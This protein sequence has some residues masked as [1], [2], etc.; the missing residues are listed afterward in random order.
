MP[1]ASAD[2]RS[3]SRRARTSGRSS[4]SRTTSPTGGR[5]RRGS[6]GPARPRPRARAGSSR[7]RRP[8]LLRRPTRAGRSLVATVRARPRLAWHVTGDHIDAELA[9]RASGPDR[10]SATLDGRSARG[11]SASARALPRQALARLHALC[12]TA[13]RAL[14]TRAPC[15]IS[16]TTSRRSRPSSSR[17]SSASSSAWRLRRTA[18]QSPTKRL[19]EDLS[20]A[21]SQAEVQR[22]PG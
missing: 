12:Q 9:A 4:P 15:S 5:D 3:C 17:S 22:E 19:E 13:A 11:C 2:A 6:A 20:R 18:R 14:G 10:T 7:R 1:R 16:A 8:A 21:E